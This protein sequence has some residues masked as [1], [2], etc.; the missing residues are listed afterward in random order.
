[1]P[2]L[3]FYRNYEMDYLK[4]KLAWEHDLMPDPFEQGPGIQELGGGHVFICAELS[5]E[6]AD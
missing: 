4:Y 3:F 2:F 1:M 6:I 5:R